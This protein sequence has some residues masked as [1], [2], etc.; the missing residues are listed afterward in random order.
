MSDIPLHVLLV[1]FLLFKVWN[2]LLD[3]WEV[4]KRE[5]TKVEYRERKKAPTQSCPGTQKALQ[6]CR[7]NRL[8]MLLPNPEEEMFTTWCTLYTKLVPAVQSHF[9]LVKLW[10]WRSVQ[11]VV[12][13]NQPAKRQILQS[14]SYIEI[15]VTQSGNRLFNFSTAVTFPS[16][17]IVGVRSRK[18]DC[19]AFRFRSKPSNYQQHRTHWARFPNR[20]HARHHAGNKR[21]RRRRM[22][23]QEQSQIV[24]FSYLVMRARNS[25][26]I[27]F[28]L[29][30]WRQLGLFFWIEP[31]FPQGA[32]GNWFQGNQFYS[33]TITLSNLLQK[34]SCLSTSRVS[35]F[36][37]DWRVTCQHQARMHNRCS[38]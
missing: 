37:T 21:G 20:R 27:L 10:I 38:L 15:H 28:R 5:E 3:V 4:V 7:E 9:L 26:L 14:K 1:L 18:E 24:A 12:L 35:T 22:V 6:V 13:S 36:V 11:T 29:E 8:Q 23:T 32:T 34:A 25:S 33:I 17:I 30:T 19:I 2:E 31:W 16:G